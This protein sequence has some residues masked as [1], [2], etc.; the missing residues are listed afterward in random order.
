MGHEGAAVPAL[1]RGRRRQA[2][3]Q[4][5]QGYGEE[6]GSEAHEVQDFREVR[7]LQPHDADPLRRANRLRREGARLGRADGVPRDEGGARKQVK[8]IFDEKFTNIPAEKST[9][10]PS[11]DILYLRKKL[12]F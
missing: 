3:A 10:K 6:E 5:H 9:N 11:K 7:E 12:R 2:A 4:G 1:P 8:A